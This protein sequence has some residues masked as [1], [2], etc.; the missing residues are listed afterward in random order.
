MKI[1]IPIAT[2]LVILATN[3][4][5]QQGLI[6]RTAEEGD[7]VIDDRDGQTYGTVKYTVT[8][9]DKTSQ[10]FTWMTRNL[11]YEMEGSFCYKDIDENCKTY[12]RLYTWK[13]ANKACPQGWHLPSDEEWYHLAFHYGGNCKCGKY[14]KSDSE[15]WKRENSRGTNESFFNA[16]PSGLGSR[17]D[18]YFRIGITALFWSSNER[19]ENSAW[20]WKL[21]GGTELQRWHGSKMA[22]NSVRCVKDE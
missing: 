6:I 5:A 17:T 10:S 2:L 12:G 8:Y 15:L 13:A 20:D 14:L 22:K 21:T 9:P 18:T 19:D 16:M 1:L 11:N 4:H 7:S 3:T